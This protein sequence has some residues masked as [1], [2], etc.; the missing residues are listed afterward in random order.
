MTR[1]RMLPRET[2]LTMQF[3]MRLQERLSSTL[4]ASSVARVTSPNTL[5]LS[6]ILIVWSRIC[7][8]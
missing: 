2:S 7:G 4:I 6:N 3:L 1:L 5:L 8:S